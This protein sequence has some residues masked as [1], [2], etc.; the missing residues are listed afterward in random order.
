M[1]KAL[2]AEQGKADMQNRIEELEADKQELEKSVLRLTAKCDDVA[3]SVLP[4]FTLARCCPFTFLLM[5]ILCARGL[6]DCWIE[7]CCS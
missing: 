6:S 3:R 2:Q 5:S 1:R 4:N 7:R